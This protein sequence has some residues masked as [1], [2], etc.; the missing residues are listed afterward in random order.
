LLDNPEFATKLGNNGREI[1]QKEFSEELVVE[2]T[3]EVY[4]LLLAG[5]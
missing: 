2:K 5:K 3:F 1:V 4:D